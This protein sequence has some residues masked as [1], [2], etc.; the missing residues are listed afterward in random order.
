MRRLIAALVSVALLWA[1]PTAWADDGLK[2]ELPVPGQA[3][4]PFDPGPTRYSAGHRGVDLEGREGDEVRAAAPGT[5]FFAG[6]VAGT[7]SVSVDHGNGLRTTYTPVSP[8]VGKGDIVSAGDVIGT[9]AAG[10]CTPQACLH[11]GLT[12]GEDYFNPLHYT[13][14]RVIRLLP[15]GSQPE[16]KVP[17]PPAL[18]PTAAT[19]DAPVSGRIT[20]RY[21]MRVHP[22]TGVYKLHDGLD[23]AAP[24]GTTI[25]LPWAG[26]VSSA[27]WDG[28]YG[29]RVIV[30]HGDGLRTAYAH[31]PDVGV[32]I[33]QELAAG[34]QVGVVGTTGY[35]TG[36]H[37]HWMA[38]RDGSLIDPES[39]LEG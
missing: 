6:K 7:P 16:I 28:G 21:G 38:W 17:L 13:E 5:I 35:S 26:T 10:H 3:V 4:R 20:S 19:G 27:G 33:G 29:Y 32:S 37:L 14:A 22:V 39:L 8:S 36:C 15:A 24:C 12:D 1:A 2:L 25:S 31:L 11:W 34:S 18:A 23:F 9:L 30:D